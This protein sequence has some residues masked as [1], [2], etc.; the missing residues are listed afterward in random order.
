MDI[1]EKMENKLGLISTISFVTEKQGSTSRIDTFKPASVF[2]I[3]NTDCEQ[4]PADFFL[5]FH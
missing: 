2:Y 3:P 1:R 4:K 5:R